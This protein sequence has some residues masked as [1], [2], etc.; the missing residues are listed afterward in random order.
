MTQ[1]PEERVLRAIHQ[2]QRKQ[3]RILARM[4]IL[5]IAALTV[6]VLVLMICGGILSLLVGAE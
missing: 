1:S 2:E 4:D 3:G 6:G 5:V